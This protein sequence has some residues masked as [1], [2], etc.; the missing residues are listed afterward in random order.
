M[1][2]DESES[3]SENE[4]RDVASPLSPPANIKAVP[5]AHHPRQIRWIVSHAVR[6]DHGVGSAYREKEDEEKQESEQ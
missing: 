6:C 2:D 4:K 3:E 1:C 5:S